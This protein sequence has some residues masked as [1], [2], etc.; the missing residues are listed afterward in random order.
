MYG[1]DQGFDGLRIS[2]W[3]LNRMMEGVRNIGRSDADSMREHHFQ[4]CGLR[5]KGRVLKWRPT[6]TTGNDKCQG[7]RATTAQPSERR[8]P[9]LHH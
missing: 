5:V 7:S 1:H 6:M 8:R 2:V 3:K 9:L 4:D